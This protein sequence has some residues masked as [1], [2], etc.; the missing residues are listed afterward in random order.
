MF[1]Q[2]VVNHAVFVI[3]T[4]WSLPSDTDR[5]GK[6]FVI[7]TGGGSLTIRVA[8]P[9]SSSLDPVVGAAMAHYH[10]ET[11]HSFNDGNGRIGRLL[12]VLQRSMRHPSGAS[13]PWAAAAEGRRA[14]LCRQWA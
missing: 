5:A 1:D 10:F 13:R 6:P 9:W 2:Y 4:C 7:I 11:L 8:G 12:I 3:I 14:R